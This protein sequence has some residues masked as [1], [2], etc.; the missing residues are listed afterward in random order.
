MKKGILIVVGN[1]LLAFSISVFL[2]DHNVLFGGVSG[3]SSV[4]TYLYP[5]S[6]NIYVYFLNFLLFILGYIWFG[7]EFSMKTIL[8]SILFPTFFSLFNNLSCLH[9]MIEDTFFSVVVGGTCMGLGIGCILSSGGSSGGLDILGLYIHKKKHIPLSYVVN[10]IDVLVILI[11]IP[12]HTKEEILYGLA[13]IVVS[14]IISHKVLLKGTSLVQLCV[15]TES[16]NEVKETLL[17]END[18]GLTILQGKKGYS[19][20]STEVILCAIPIQKLH[21]LQKNI[22]DIDEHAFIILSDVKGVQG[23]RFTN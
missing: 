4:L 11:Q 16:Y 15:I 18:I 22:L 6:I 21:D 19:D 13:A 3:V 7:K 9:P 10:G 8:S 17:K 23:Y 2:K 1:F 20:K 12:F 14:T 5:I